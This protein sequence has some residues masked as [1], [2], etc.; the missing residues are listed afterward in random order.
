MLINLVVALV[1]LG[2]LLYLINN[3]IPMDGRIKQLVN[4]VVVVGAVLWCM[5]AFGI[6]VMGGPLMTLVIALCVLGVLLWIINAYIPMDGRIKNIVNVV[7]LLVAV[8]AVLQAFGII[9]QMH[10]L[11]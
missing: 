6:V 5:Q 10:T 9:P 3:F 8:L 2:V 4:V 1:I 11:S 7:I